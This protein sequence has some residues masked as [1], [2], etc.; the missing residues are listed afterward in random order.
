[1]CARCTRR[2]EGDCRLPISEGREVLR[3]ENSC[4]DT[5][6]GHAGSD[7]SDGRRR[8]RTLIGGAAVLAVF[9]VL[10]P[11]KL[12]R[13]GYVF[14][15]QENIQITEAQAWWS[16]RLDLP[17][18]TW[19]T[20]LFN[21]RVYSYFPPMFTIL[22]A[23]VVPFFD[24]IPHGLI[25]AMVL[26]VPLCAYVLFLRLTGSECWGAILAIGLVCGTSA[27]PVLDKTVRGAATYP[28][29]HTLSTVGLLLILIEFFGRR[30]VWPACLGLAL[31]ALSRQLTVAYALP[32]ALMSLTGAPREVR[33]RRLAVLGLTCVGLAVLYGGLNF[34]KFGHPLT[35]GYML[36]HEGRDDVFAREAREHGLLSWHWVPRNLYYSNLGLP[37]LHRVMIEGEERAFVRPN[38]MG[39]GIW[40][41]TPLLL[42][43]CVETRRL[44]RDRQAVVWLG[45]AGLVYG[46]LLFWHA[47]GAVQRG[48]NRYSLDYVPVLLALVAPTCCVGWR[49]WVSLAM[50]GWSVLYFRWLI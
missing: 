29:N 25:V 41:T 50:V 1:M 8:R 20:A 49:R 38:T 14:T 5:A 15:G 40:W 13:P 33:G 7:P 46:M 3:R 37:K 12:W 26:L 43:I 6:V 34:L 47:T 31:T 48:F 36:N 21:G 9:G 10:C 30:R 27:F 11:A 35:T 19:D 4:A 23:A 24:G 2:T 17:E 18:R 45:A 32:I 39:T 16:G 22:A 28:V 44:L 42:W